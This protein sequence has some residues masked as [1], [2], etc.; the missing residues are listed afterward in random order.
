MNRTVKLPIQTRQAS[1]TPATLNAE[2][3]TVD[4]V[5]TTGAAV[6]RYDS[7]TDEVFLEE[8]V[9]AGADLSRLNAGAN[10]LDSHDDSSL[11]NV[12]GVVERAWLDKEKKQGYA[13]LRF[14]N[15]AEIDPIWQDVQTGILRNI[16]VGYSID[17][18]ERLKAEPKG[19]G[20][21]TLRVLRFTPMELSLL[22]VAADAGA[23]VRVNPSTFPCNLHE[24]SP[25]TDE[26]QEVVETSTPPIV[27]PDLSLIPALKSSR[28]QAEALGAR[29]A[30]T[31]ERQRI[32]DL[33]ELFQ[34]ALVPRTEIFAN[35]RTLAVNQGWQ[36]EATR[37]YLMEVISSDVEPVFDHTE[38]VADGDM[39]MQHAPP[40]MP[41]ATIRT[42]PSLPIPPAGSWSRRGLGRVEVTRDAAETAVQSI[43][44]A[45]L[46]RCGIETD[47][48]IQKEA[49]ERG[50]AGLTYIEMGR[51]L[52]EV[53]GQQS[54]IAGLD[55]HGVAKVMLTRAGPMTASDF[56]GILANVATK[57]AKKG[58]TETPT[59]YQEWCNIGYLPDFKAATIPGLGAF[60]DLD[61]IPTGGGPYFYG[62]FGDNYETATLAT[63][64]KL[65]GIS[66]H[67]LVNDDLNLFS[68]TGLAMGAAAK[69]KVNALAYAVLTSPSLV[70][71]TMTEDGHPLFY[72]THN[73]LVANGSGGA[74][75]TTTLSA[76][77]TAMATQTSPKSALESST[78]YMSTSPAHLIVP[79]GLKAT[80]LVLNESMYDPGGT[81][82]S[83]SRRDAPNIWRGRLQ[84]TSDPLVI[85]AEGWF[86]A[87]QQGNPTIDTVTVFFLEG[88][89]GE[90]YTEEQTQ[91]DSDGISYKVRID[92]VARA[93]DYRGL[94]FNDGN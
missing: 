28:A 7:W 60:S 15:R 92:A 45:L 55:K 51:R 13:T 82:S 64:G 8:L 11:R 23:Q 58:Y 52:F 65:F 66:R 17:Q 56:T 25:M 81:T 84:V 59:T 78:L 54:R 94:Y 74:P 50:F 22:A 10:V 69:R 89:G 75:S 14:S 41:P 73:N 39:G 43:E 62:T 21:D 33:D 71:Q 2:A 5:W 76:A 3:R 77:E 48:T 30:I 1:F 72:S 26:I 88:S 79:P 80:A 47:K 29:K 93:L 68:R 12:I 4:V 35:I 67:A 16:S 90:P 57:I 63:Y 27:P 87:A 53:S 9:V 86:L 42:P 31:A 24:V 49:R 36:V 83:V 61:Q 70:G 85:P 18:A 37:K 32:S 38:I 20:P 44:Q 46:V 6:K 40:A 34:L 19:A 91:F